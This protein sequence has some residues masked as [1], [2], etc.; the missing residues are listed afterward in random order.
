MPLQPRHFR[1]GG[2]GFLFG[3]GAHGIGR[4]PGYLGIIDRGG[5]DVAAVPEITRSMPATFAM[6]AHR[7]A[8]PVAMLRAMEHAVSRA[9]D[10]G[11]TMGVVGATTH[12]GAIGYDAL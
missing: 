7:A 8:G 6:A 4:V 12:T 2:N 5:L 10:S 1:L 11:M 3:F 9:P